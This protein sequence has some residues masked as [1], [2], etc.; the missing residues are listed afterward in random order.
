MRHPGA[1]SRI[2]ILGL[3]VFSIAFSVPDVGLAFCVSGVCF[4]DLR[5]KGRRGGG[6][7]GG[8]YVAPVPSG[9]SA[10]ELRKQREEKDLREAADDAND[11]G[12]EYAEKG[13]WGNAVK[14]WKR[15]LS[16]SRTIKT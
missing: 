10:E 7:G 9:P 14:S 6:G 11:K 12:V 3:L 2:P 8:G 13:D 16:T 1:A 5:I 15:R 4:D